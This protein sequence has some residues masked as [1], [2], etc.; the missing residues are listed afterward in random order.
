MRAPLTI[1]ENPRARLG[2]QIALLKTPTAQLAVN[3][4]SQHPDKRKAGG[5]GPTLAD[6]IEHLLPTPRAT[7]GTNGGPNA[8]GSDGDP[9][10][11]MV[12][13]IV[14]RAG[15]W[16]KYAAAIAR[17]EAIFGVPVPAPRVLSE[18]GRWVLSPLL[19]EWMMGLQPGHITGHDLSRNDA[20]KAGGNGVVPQQA[21]HAV[22]SLLA[23]AFEGAV[24]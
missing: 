6:E 2:D 18:R 12:A 21:M 9:M 22:A 17:W 5:H 15:T 16:G 11:P 20:I 8:R 3:G 4:G 24:V 10:M 23:R 19:V 7:D 1:R 14:D 13:A